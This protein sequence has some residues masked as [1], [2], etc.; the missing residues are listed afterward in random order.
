M[1]LDILLR[2]S[3]NFPSGA[4]PVMPPLESCEF[5]TKRPAR[6]NACIQV[7]LEPEANEG[8]VL[9]FSE[10][11]HTKCDLTSSANGKLDQRIYYMVSNMDIHLLSHSSSFQSIGKGCIEIQCECFSYAEYLVRVVR[12]WQGMYCTPLGCYSQIDTF[13]IADVELA[14]SLPAARLIPSTSEAPDIPDGSFDNAYGEDAEWVFVDAT[15]Q[16]ISSPPV[17]EACSPQDSQ[18]PP[19]AVHPSTRSAQIVT[20]GPCHIENVTV[21]AGSRLVLGKFT[22]K[23]I[24]TLL[25]RDFP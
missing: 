24:R 6:T 15:D 4:D 23:E 8:G 13:W 20:Q 9:I 25:R 21:G 1:S 3:N 12:H 2:R 19:P 10:L 7:Q 18:A 11:L 22:D 16:P 5:C 14:S 17:Q